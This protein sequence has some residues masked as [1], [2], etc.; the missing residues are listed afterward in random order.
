MLDKMG[1]R[2]TN[3]T[4]RS[5]PRAKPGGTVAERKNQASR[6]RD[7]GRALLVCCSAFV[8]EGGMGWARVQSLLH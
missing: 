3:G 8:P 6:K 4:G 2:R 5:Q 1:S 7:A